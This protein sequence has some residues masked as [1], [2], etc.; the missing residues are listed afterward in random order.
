MYIGESSENLMHTDLPLCVVKLKA[1]QTC[2]KALREPWSKTDWIWAPR[3]HKSISPNHVQ[4]YKAEMQQAPISRIERAWLLLT[5]QNPT[6]SL[7]TTSATWGAG[8]QD[9]FSPISAFST[10]F[11]LLRCLHKPKT[12]FG[13]DVRRK[14]LETPQ[15]VQFLKTPLP[16]HTPYTVV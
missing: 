5:F 1:L 16:L 6:A 12:N 8:F 7:D 13:Q 2:T 9:H 3:R 10:A 15:P 4:I 11:Q 14:L